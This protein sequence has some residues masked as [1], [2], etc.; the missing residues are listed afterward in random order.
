MHTNTAPV[1][2]NE[3][4]FHFSDTKYHLGRFQAIMFSLLGCT[5]AMKIAV[6]TIDYPHSLKFYFSEVSQLLC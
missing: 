1:E 4:V 5:T 2:A 3:E 6:N